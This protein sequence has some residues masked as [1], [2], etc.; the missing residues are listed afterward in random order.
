[1]AQQCDG[2][3]VL[4]HQ[5]SKQRGPDAEHESAFVMHE[6]RVVRRIGRYHLVERARC[7]ERPRPEA[8]VKDS[9]KHDHRGDV[10]VLP[11]CSMMIFRPHFIHPLPALPQRQSS[12]EPSDT[13]PTTATYKL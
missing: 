2:L 1:A 6:V 9:R 7:D 10:S 12:T 13:P 8:D 4:P 5:G 11:M 3:R